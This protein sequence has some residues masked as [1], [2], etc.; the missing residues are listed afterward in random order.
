MSVA[1][2]DDYSLSSEINRKGYDSLHRI[3]TSHHKG[4]LDDRGFHTALDTLLFTVNGLVE[5]DLTNLIGDFIFKSK[6]SQSPVICYNYKRPDGGMAIIEWSQSA[7]RLTM[8]I[9]VPH[10]SGIVKVSEYKDDPNWQDSYRKSLGK[11]DS[12]LIAGGFVKV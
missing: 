2:L 9:I 3:V 10:K 5:D 8:T 4:L 11:I 12:Q 6:V 1:A 7:L